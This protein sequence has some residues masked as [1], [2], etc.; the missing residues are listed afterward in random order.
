[1]STFNNAHQLNSTKKTKK[2][3]LQEHLMNCGLRITGNRAVLLGRLRE[4]AENRDKWFSL[5]QSQAKRRRGYMTGAR[6]ASTTEKRIVSLFG[7]NNVPGSHQ[8][9]KGSTI[10]PVRPLSENQTSCNDAW[11]AAVLLAAES[12]ASTGNT[13]AIEPEVADIV[14]YNTRH[15]LQHIQS[16]IHEVCTL[17]QQGTASRV[18]IPRSRALRHLVTLQTKINLKDNT[19][20]HEVAIEV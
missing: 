4:F 2:K 5:Y 15:V 7:S 10:R 20:N 8:L 19:T 12:P 6:T 9:K 3:Y 16:D 13:T 17:I 14:P 18:D 1:M 11:A